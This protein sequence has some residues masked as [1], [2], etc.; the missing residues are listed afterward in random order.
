MRE[1]LAG[2]RAESQYLGAVLGLLLTAVLD[3]ST[4]CTSF[5]LGSERDSAR[6]AGLQEEHRA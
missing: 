3:R 2:T 6:W 5:W 4:F 1:A